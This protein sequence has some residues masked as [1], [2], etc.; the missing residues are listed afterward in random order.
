VAWGWYFLDRANGPIIWT[1]GDGPHPIFGMRGGSSERPFISTLQI[2]GNNRTDE[3]VSNIDGFL[4]SNITNKTLPLFFQINGKY[5]RTIDTN[6]V[7]PHADFMIIVPF[8]DDQAKFETIAIPSDQFLSEYGDLTLSVMFDGRG[9][10]YV[11][12]FP[13]QELARVID[14]FEKSLR[15]SNQRKPTITLK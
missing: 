2:T 4:R 13:R 11:R 9:S 7:P 5:V 10:P 12:N 6:G 1:F 3:P 8:T 14:E 15:D